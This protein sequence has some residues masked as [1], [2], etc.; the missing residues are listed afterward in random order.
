MTDQ[1]LARRWL[2]EKSTQ[3]GFRDGRSGRAFHYDFVLPGEDANQS[4]LAYELGHIVGTSSRTN[5]IDP[6][7]YPNGSPSAALIALFLSEFD[8]GID[9][10]VDNLIEP[11]RANPTGQS[12]EVAS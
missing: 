7:H 1:I 12:N 11:R 2:G 8:F 4:S 5:K 9:R 6:G 10:N 3:F